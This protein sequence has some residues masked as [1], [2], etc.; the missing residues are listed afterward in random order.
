MHNCDIN[1]K[2]LRSLSNRFWNKKRC[3]EHFSFET[4]FQINN[5]II[6]FEYKGWLTTAMIAQHCIKR[7]ENWGLTKIDVHQCPQQSWT[8]GTKLL[9]RQTAVLSI[10]QVWNETNGCVENITCLITQINE[11]KF[12]LLYTCKPLSS[13]NVCQLLPFQ[14]YSCPPA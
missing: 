9:L 12:E 6:M 10:V 7:V 8:I 2:Q 13:W 5:E 3:Q 14:C 11:N 4:C 1:I